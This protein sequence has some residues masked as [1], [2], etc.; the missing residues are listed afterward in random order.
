MDLLLLQL[1]NGLVSGAFYALLA[2]GLAL[3]L[4]LTRIINLA[5]GGFLVVGAYLGYVL[6]GLLGFYP[7]LLLALLF[8]ALM[9]PGVWSSMLAVGLSMV[10][11]FF[12]VARAGA[13]S[14]KT[15]P[16]VEAALALGA[17]PTRVLLRHLLPN[18]LGP[19]LVQASLAF[20]AALLAEAALA[21]LGLGVQ[22]PSPSLGRMLRE[23]QSFLPLSPYPAL[24]PGLALSLAV[25]G[26][27]L[28]G[29]GLRDLLDPR[30]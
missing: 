10:P 14:L 25:L 23:A 6:T 12:R 20:A 26:F 27:N 13:L 7:A 3:I 28:L 2:L 30:R 1:L 4:S 22:P 5:H 15:A 8:A 9:G 18:L 17:T 29:D 16:F 11:A 19:L 24:I 21:Y